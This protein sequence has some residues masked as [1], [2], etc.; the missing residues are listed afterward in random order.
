MARVYQIATVLLVAVVA[1]VSAV[2]FQLGSRQPSLGGVLAPKREAVLGSQP[3]NTPVPGFDKN[4][5]F[6]GSAKLEQGEHGNTLKKQEEDISLGYIK[7]NEYGPGQP[8][9]P[10]VPNATPTPV[11][12]VQLVSEGWVDEN[13]PH[14]DG[15]AIP[16]KS[17]FQRVASTEL[18]HKTMVDKRAR[19]DPALWVDDGLVK[20]KPEDLVKIDPQESLAGSTSS[21]DSSIP[22]QTDPVTQTGVRYSFGPDEKHQKRILYPVTAKFVTSDPTMVDETT[23]QLNEMMNSVPLQHDIRTPVKG[24]DNDVIGA[25]KSYSELAPGI[26]DTPET[27]SLDESIPA[28]NMFNGASGAIDDVQPSDI[29]HFGAFEKANLGPWEKPVEAEPH[30]IER[31]PFRQGME[32]PPPPNRA[33]QAAK[34]G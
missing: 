22:S 17:N 16:P 18:D 7:T 1:S 15:N 12:K 5:A 13:L 19:A 6:I 23:T 14:G 24:E 29:N 25:K 26:H 34:H 4:G 11:D 21:V 33:S 8:Y 31:T 32:D 28:T 20:D 27:R 30:Q 2:H 9:I 3:A 10:G